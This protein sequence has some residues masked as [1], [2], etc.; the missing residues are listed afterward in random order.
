M[1][2]SDLAP[3]LLPEKRSVLIFGNAAHCLFA[4]AI[5]RRPNAAFLP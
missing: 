2:Y 4:R 3:H 5:F 1:S